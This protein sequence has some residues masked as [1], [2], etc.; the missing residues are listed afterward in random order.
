MLKKTKEKELATK[1][2]LQGKTYDEILEY[3]SVSKST[4]SLWL[5]DVGLSAR[6]KHKLTTRKR[7]AQLKGALARKN[8][9]RATTREIFK[10][11]IDSVGRLSKREKFLIG[12]ALYWAEGSKEKPHNHGQGVDFGNTDSSMIDFYVRW[13]QDS[14]GVD[15]KDIS[16]KLYIHKNHESRIDEV[17]KFWQEVVPVPQFQISYVYFKKHNPKTKRRKID[18]ESYHGTLRITVARSTNLQRKIQG[19]IYGITGQPCPVV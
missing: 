8:A 18:K 7:I 4:L 15:P 11:S 9:R 1:L 19:S 14:L 16:F 2:R 12:V 17:K 3:V 6:Q 13:L 10:K 5:R